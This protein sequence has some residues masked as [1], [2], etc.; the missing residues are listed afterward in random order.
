M[1][2]FPE[3]KSKTQI[4]VRV[5]VQQHANRL[6]HQVNKVNVVIATGHGNT[7]GHFF[8]QPRLEFG[9]EQALVIA[10]EEIGVDGQDSRPA[11]N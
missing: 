2:S 8:R 6:R 10:N 3:E 11:I 7:G 5:K 1:R 4:H 9:G